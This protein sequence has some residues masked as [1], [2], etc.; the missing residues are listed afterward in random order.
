MPIIS[1]S[2]T[3]SQVQAAVRSFLLSVLPTGI[4]VVQGQDNR[5]AEP[6]GTDF[7]VLWQIRRER[8]ETNID[9][10]ADCVFQGSIAGTQLTVQNIIHGSLLAGSTLLSGPNV[11]GLMIVNQLTGSGPGTPPG[12]LGTY[13]LSGTGTATNETMSCGVFMAI[14]PT[15]IVFQCNVHGPNSA[16]NA[17]MITTLFRDFYGVA[18]FVETTGQEN[19]APLYADDPKQVPFLNAE[20]QLETR[21]IVEAH[22]QANQ[23]ITN[24][25]EFAG[26]V[27]VNF[28]PQF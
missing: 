25:Q 1:F 11:Y 7:I 23:V 27:N 20:Q 19:I 5:V 3:S 15:E 13:A 9:L 28:F 4:E 14:Q 18:N 10:Y 8:L 2:P 22:V 24:P 12:G 17:Q 16:D 6:R 21:W 26:Q